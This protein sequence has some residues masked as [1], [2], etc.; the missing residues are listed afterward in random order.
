MKKS[1]KPQKSP[2]N[3]S[4]SI[5]FASPRPNV[6]PPRPKFASPSTEFAPPRPFS[7][8]FRFPFSTFNC[9]KLF[10]FALFLAAT[11]SHAQVVLT[12]TV[13]DDGGHPLAGVA[14]ASDDGKFG[15]ITD[16]D[17]KFSLSVDNYGIRLN[18]SL[19]GYRSLEV[20]PE[21][22]GE[23]TATLP[24]EETYRLGE[25]VFTGYSVQRRGAV[26]GSAATVTGEELERSPAANLSQALT[27]RLPG[28]YTYES[29]S[30]PSRTLTNLYVR[31]AGTRYANA[32]LVVI[33]GIPY[34]YNSSEL[35]EY[36]SAMEIESVSVLKDASTQALYG[37]QGASGVIVVTT[38]RGVQ[39]KVRVN[40]RIDQIFEQPTTRLPF[41]GS[42]DY[43]R[44]RNEAGYND[45][46]G[47]YAFFSE[48]EVNGYLAGTNREVYPD[49]NWREINMK[50]LTSMQRIG[51]NVTGG[52]ARVAF[53]TNVNAMHQD[54]MWKTDQ[55]K[56]DPNNNFW[57]ANFRTNVDAKLNRY[58]K[59]SMNL[60]G[61]IKREKTPGGGYTDGIYYRLYSVP[62]Y[63]YGPVTPALTDPQ[64]GKTSEAGGV[65]VSSTESVPAYAAINRIGYSQITRTNIYAQF[66]MQM[67]MSF[68]TEGLNL[69]GSMAYQTNSTN[70][71]NVTQSFAAWIRTGNRD[72]LQFDPYGTAVDAPL[73]YGKTSS[74]YYNLNYKGILDYK[75]RFG[76][77]DAAAFVFSHY[78][79]LVTPSE[80]F[81][82]K[83]VNTGLELAYGYDGR[84]LI[85]YD[86]GYSG[87]DQYSREKRFTPIQAVAVGWVLSEESFADGI[88][89]L[90]LLKLRASYGQAANDQCEL[91]RYTYLDNISLTSG[92]ANEGQVANPSLAPEIS[93]RQN[94]GIDLSLW[95]NVSVSVDIFREKTNNA[96]CGGISVTPLYQGVLLDNFPK[97]NSGVFENKGYELAA[98]Y[99]KTVNRRFSFHAGGWL[100]H[101]QNRVVFVDESERAEDY[102]YR[103]WQEGYP[104]GQQFG[105]LV[106][107]HNG[108]GYFNSAGEL[109]G[110][111]LIYEI[112]TPRTGD[113]K[114]YDLNSDGIINEK[115]KAPIGFGSLPLY[116]Y[117]FHA[118]A[119]FGNFDLTVMFQGVGGFYR[120]LQGDGRVEYNFEGVYGTW[121]RNAWTEERYAGGEKIS[122]PALSTKANANHEEGDFWLENRSYLRLKNLELGYTFPDRAARFIGAEKIRLLLSG[123]NLFTWH[124]LDT[125]D[126]GPEG[127]YMSIPV[128]RLYNIGL[129]LKF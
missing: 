91:E 26:T 75:R 47:P 5:E 54:G 92:Y 44:L 101:T 94:Y 12:G 48:S 96:V 90:S 86:L 81:P 59:A 110:S 84:Y 111:G 11:P 52:N 38:K 115:D 41:L 78:Q 67:D 77:H 39:G 60:S 18:L 125:N 53:F 25:R 63:V 1:Q 17:G 102:A 70:S 103:K 106:D 83:R 76:R 119:A 20:F 43:T 28:L 58:L 93:L 27:G 13:G 37:I 16:R 15:T 87:S 114:Y 34:T 72:E 50:D 105:Y 88:S 71:L 35:F 74:F 127:R 32:P 99:I 4:A 14:V 95:G 23:I 82:Y 117:A 116:T 9:L 21:E 36:V 124:R 109:N 79:Y 65:V 120:T 66:A 10:V 40:A 80:V 89:W 57:W 19:Q 85:K 33:D 3:L 31:G 107:R 73:A 118:G 129:S 6:A 104:V 112:G 29:Y 62:P 122:F 7:S 24:R 56:Y 64:T 100:A 113:L 69:T 68:L 121:H 123:Q 98:D 22:A 46:M 42:A 49:N 126:Y 55:T 108:N 128:Y 45:G 51:V 30:E 8:I 61:N 2:T 97:V